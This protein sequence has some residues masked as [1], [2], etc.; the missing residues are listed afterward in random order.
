[1]CIRDRYITDR[2]N[3]HQVLVFDAAGRPKS[4]IG[5]AGKPQAGP[6]DP[7]HMNNPNG[8][9]LDSQGR[10]WVAET[11]YQPKRVSIW[12]PDG[13]FV[14]AFYGP[15]QY[16]GGGTLD[17]R[18]P[19]RFYYNAMEFRLDWKTGRDQ[20]VNVYHRSDSGDQP[21]SERW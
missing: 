2:G 19:T 10:L 1:M 13:S 17:G 11:D 3:H 18:N 9:T 16:G 12:R 15:G 7:L 5:K 14:R 20:L 4:A 6:Y 21:L 8:V